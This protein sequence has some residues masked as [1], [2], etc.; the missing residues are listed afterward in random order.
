MSKCDD[1]SAQS[2]F[3]QC[4]D[5]NMNVGSPMEKCQKNPPCAFS[6]QKQRPPQK[7]EA[8]FFL[9][10]Y[11][12]WL[13]FSRI[14]YM[15]SLE[16]SAPLALRLWPPP[17]LYHV[18]CQEKSFCCVWKAFVHHPL[19]ARDCNRY[20]SENNWLKW[21]PTYQWGAAHIETHTERGLFP[22]LCTQFQEVTEKLLECQIYSWTM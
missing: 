8:S 12:A 3:C 13:Q 7:K 22:L 20:S 14:S 19:C 9:A 18:T 6:K 5:I 17:D 2:P 15:G 10:F 1:T 16:L 21:G 4:G 11:S